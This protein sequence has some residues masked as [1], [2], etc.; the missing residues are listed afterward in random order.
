MVPGEL[1]KQAYVG[2]GL[3]AKNLSRTLDDSGCTTLVQ[4]RRGTTLNHCL[5]RLLR[6]RALRYSVGVYPV[7]R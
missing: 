1:F 4:G 6:S 5:G 7:T 2:R 3:D